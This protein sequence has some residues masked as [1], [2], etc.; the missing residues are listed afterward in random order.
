[1]DD[2]MS[3]LVHADVA[4]PSRGVLSFGKSD[5]LLA[6]KECADLGIDS[7]VLHS[8]GERCK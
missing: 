1:M 4:G 7:P 6:G 2:G 3:E 8:N 5:H